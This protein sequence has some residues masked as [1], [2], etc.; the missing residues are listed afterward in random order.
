MKRLSPILMRRGF[1]GNWA[2]EDAVIRKVGL[3]LRLVTSFTDVIQKALRL[4]VP[5]FQCFLLSQQSGTILEPTP[6]DVASFLALRKKH[7]GDVYVHGSYWINLAGIRFAKHFSLDRE[8]ALAK[9]L[10]FTHM[11]LHPGSAKGAKAKHE[12]IEAMARAIN[13]TMRTEHT[14]KIVLEN[15]AFARL[16]VGGDLEDFRQLLAKLDHPEK[17]L[18]CIDT[19]HAYSYGYDL[20]DPVKR[21]A[22]IAQLDATIGID[23]I[24][25]LHIN[26]TQEACG[27]RQDRH[28]MFG[29]GLLGESTLR[30]FAMHDKLKHIPLLLELPIVSEADERIILDKVKSWHS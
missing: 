19:A 14:I 13:K 7:F 17:I 18:F 5:I 30:E 11:V 10:E 6:E 9:R 16:S 15:T 21:E 2:C 12:G 4:E 27:S 22:F 1:Q 8:L 26:D 25:L 29:T 24:A 3:H 28:A 20:V 23:R